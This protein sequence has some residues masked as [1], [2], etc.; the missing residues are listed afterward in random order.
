MEIRDLTTADL[1]VFEA[2]YRSLSPETATL[3]RPFGWEL[4]RAD[5]LTHLRETEAG[6]HLS[7]GLF[8]E[9]G[10][11]E[12]HGFMLY[13][14]QAQPSFGL[15]LRDRMQ[16]QGW[17]PKLMAAVMEDPRVASLP[18]TTLTVVKT[19]DRARRI[20]ERWGYVI[21]TEGAPE[22]LTDREWYMER[23]I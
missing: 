12:G 20:Y 21:V 10:E 23:R 22:W 13:L 15:G 17:G 11:M 5:L 8:N 6:E 7:L 9:A 4:R 18:L 16:G 2:F 3:F 19:N 1:E 14:G